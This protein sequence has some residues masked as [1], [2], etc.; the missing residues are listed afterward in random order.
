MAHGYDSANGSYLTFV[1]WIINLEGVGGSR[2]DQKNTCRFAAVLPSKNQILL[3][4][5]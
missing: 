5:Q 1:F 2:T 4:A 3:V